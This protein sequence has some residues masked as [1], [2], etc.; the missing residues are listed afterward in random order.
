MEVPH[1]MLFRYMERRKQDLETCLDSLRQ[2]NYSEIEK[3]GHQLKGNG[4]T[5][6]FAD[7]SDIG[8]H[9]EKAAAI[10]NLSETERAL[11]EFSSWVNQHL[12]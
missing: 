1:E 12:N 9:M 7:L 8:L 4:I 5:F 11:D 10:K 3:V 2:N 6:G